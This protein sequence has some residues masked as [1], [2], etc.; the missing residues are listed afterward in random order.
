[1]TEG[2]FPKVDGDKLYASEINNILQSICTLIKIYDG[3]ELDYDIDDDI[4]VGESPITKNK[5]F[6]FDPTNRDIVKLSFTYL[7]RGGC[8]S[9]VAS[10]SSMGLTYRIREI[11][12][13]WRDVYVKNQHEY[14]NTTGNGHMRQLN[15]SAS[16]IHYIELTED[17]KINGYEIEIEIVG[18]V[19]T[20]SNAINRRT[21]VQNNQI[22]FELIKNGD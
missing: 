13:S 8:N 6:T 9:T 19:W 18:T 20:M 5:I 15:K 4:D 22:V 7:W 1:M 2:Q 17:E 3:D 10:F 21:A 12:G 16:F 14:V 11:G